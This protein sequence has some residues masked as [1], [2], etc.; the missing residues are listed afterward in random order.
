M[1][2]F[3][4]KVVFGIFIVL[5]I[6]FIYANCSSPFQDAKYELDYVRLK[7]KAKEAYNYCKE[8]KL[9]TNYCFLLDMSIHSG[10]ERF[11]V[12]DFIKDTLI[13][14]GMVSHGCGDNP[15]GGDYSKTNPEFSNTPESHLSSLG[16]FKIGARGYSQWGININYK[17]H[18]LESTNSKAYER[19]IVLHS[20][21]MIPNKPNYPS[22]TPEGWGCPAVSND[23]MKQLDE[24][25]KNKPKDVLLWIYKD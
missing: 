16:K 19:F 3:M 8:K 5:F 17:L 4:I 7:A 20:W 21:D 11:F 1:K 24:R 25:L 14:K 15:W 10:R 22:G 6:P 12:W 13:E 2:S 9:E 18:G 23:F